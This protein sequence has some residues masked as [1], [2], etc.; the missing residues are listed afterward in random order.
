MRPVGAR[1]SRGLRSL[2]R[3]PHSLVGSDV[4]DDIATGTGNIGLELVDIAANIDILSERSTDQA[5]LFSDL[6]DD[7]EAMRM[8][9]R[10]TATA[11]EEARE[12]AH[13]VTE[14]MH[15]S[16]QALQTSLGGLQDLVGWVERIGGQMEGLVKMVQN[17]GT[18]TQQVEEIAGRTRILALNA[19]IE[20]VRSGQ[21]GLGFTVIAESVNE[22]AQQSIEAA[23][24]IETTLGGLTTQI[25]MLGEQGSQTRL[26][27]QQAE[28]DA[29][30]IGRSI[31]SVATA[32]ERIDEQMVG[33]AGA[34][35]DVGDKVERLVDTL[36]GL[37][38]GVEQ[39][40]VELSASRDRVNK[41][42]DHVEQLIGLTSQ[43][44][45]ETSD[46]PFIR[47]IVQTAGETS[48]L[49]ERAVG[50]G[51]V[52]L[53]DM[54][55]DTYRTIPGSN[56]EQYLTR[57]TD[58]VR[59]VL[60]YGFE[61]LLSVDPHITF[62]TP[63]DRNGYAPTHNKTFSQPQ[64]DDPAWNAAHCRDRRIFNDRSGL[65]AARSTQP[66][67]LQTHRRDMGDGNFILMKDISAPI[68]LS[69]RHWGAV[70]MGYRVAD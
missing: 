54:F 7:A 66:F 47:L 1:R 23:T 20:A 48:A 57:F 62:S 10:L 29:L 65:A 67:L 8:A 52:S 11:S 40:S 6:R 19:R 13:E 58:F 15:E 37:T 45:A 34:T 22:L 69:G 60:P 51:E 31:E 5:L 53:E 42:L 43:T 63:V 25:R 21:A 38:S 70:R 12:A 26:K 9:N 24:N 49:F 59:R 28:A 68:T 50:A 3:K 14:Q 61:Q 33:I 46:S 41:L 4:I 55:D 44:G 56:P 17:V 16:Q 36:S 32:V 2:L 35:G 39:S 27:A 18:I 64:G 30:A